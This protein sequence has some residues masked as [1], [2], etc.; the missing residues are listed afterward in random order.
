M[1]IK[2]RKELRKKM[3]EHNISSVEVAAKAGL[4]TTDVSIRLSTNTTKEDKIIE[5][6]EALIKERK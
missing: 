4:T 2:E 1:D 6:I 3:L 5:A